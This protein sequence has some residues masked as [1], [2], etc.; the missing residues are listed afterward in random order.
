MTAAMDSGFVRELTRDAFLSEFIQRRRHPHGVTEEPWIVRENL[1]SHLIWLFQS[2][3]TFAWEHTQ[4]RSTGY[5]MITVSETLT[6]LLMNNS[7]RDTVMRLLWQDSTCPLLI[8]QAI[9]IYLAEF[10]LH[11]S[12]IGGIDLQIDVGISGLLNILY[13][14]TLPHVRSLLWAVDTQCDQIF[15]DAKLF[16]Q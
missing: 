5:T 10:V 3:E 11:L 13:A 7:N 4:A 14:N 12:V 1:T 9:N 15:P 8:T 16:C 2:I 6:T